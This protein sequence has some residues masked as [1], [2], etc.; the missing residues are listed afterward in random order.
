M[1]WDKSRMN[2]HLWTER[3]ED[4]CVCCML[5]VLWAFVPTSPQI[6]L[7]VSHG[8]CC[9]REEICIRTFCFDR[10][11][12]LPF[13]FLVWKSGDIF[14]LSCSLCS[15]FTVSFFSISSDVRDKTAGFILGNFF[16]FV[17]VIN[18]KID[19]LHCVHCSKR[20]EVNAPFKCWYYPITMISSEQQDYLLKGNCCDPLHSEIGLLDIT[21]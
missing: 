1:R 9:R 17:V 4:F 7:N 10:L 2:L 8:I 11:S 19:D 18:H 15:F 5:S 21:I 16:F 6:S 14:A 13:P 12:V 3:E 20:K